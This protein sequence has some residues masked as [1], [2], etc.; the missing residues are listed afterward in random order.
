[1][2]HF[3]SPCKDDHINL[4]LRFGQNQISESR[5]KVAIPWHFLEEVFNQPELFIII[6]EFIIN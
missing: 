5:N 1:M 4:N 3:W 2:K 6:Q